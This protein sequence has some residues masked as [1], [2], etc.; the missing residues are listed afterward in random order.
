[1]IRRHGTGQPRP[2]GSERNGPS[3]RCEG[4]GRSVV[5]YKFGDHQTRIAIGPQ[6]GWNRPRLAGAD[7]SI[8]QDLETMD[9]RT[10]P[11]EL[12]AMIALL[13]YI[14]RDVE[15]LNPSAAE[16]LR[17][18]RTALQSHLRRRFGDGEEEPIGPN[19]VICKP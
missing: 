11:D 15:E 13:A 19:V 17:H 16:H 6:D 3:V 5:A 14:D 12:K 4:Q 8:R 9:A 2:G 10:R 18:A 1:M 7:P